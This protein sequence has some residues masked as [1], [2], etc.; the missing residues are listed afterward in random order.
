MLG[1]LRTTMQPLGAIAALICALGLALPGASH[2]APPDGPGTDDVS[3]QPCNDVC[4][5]YMAWSDRVA[6]KLHPSSTVA[7]TTAQDGKP[8]GQMVHHH[9][10]K[11]RQPSLNSFARLPVRRDATAQSAETAQAVVAPSR[12]V[13]GIT[14]RFPTTAGFVSALLAGAA[15]AANDAPDSPIVSV[16]EVTPAT[17]AGGAIDAT[18]TIDATV[19]GPDMQFA[20]SLCLALCLLAALVV[21]G[22]SRARTQTPRVLR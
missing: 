17:R 22:W 12:P 10:A 20:V 6:A 3:A 18:S 21:W 13:D 15:G 1:R 11:S 7:Q 5:A 16:T 2:A 4:K 14:D 8:A 9:A 19:R